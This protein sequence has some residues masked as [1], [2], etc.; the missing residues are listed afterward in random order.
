[1]MP[2]GDI[3]VILAV[4]G[5]PCFVAWAW[6]YVDMLNVVILFSGIA[7]GWWARDRLG[8][9]DATTSTTVDGSRTNASS[10]SSAGGF[11]GVYEDP[12][13]CAKWEIKD[14]CA[15]I[16]VREKDGRVVHGW[17]EGSVLTLQFKEHN[18]FQATLRGSQLEWKTGVPSWV[19][20]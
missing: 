19:K 6:L 11:A 13:E 9:A 12:Q 15:V 14:A 1:M 4:L 16:A 20:K 18:K 5:L 3:P 8:A 10:A 7:F 17:F 2:A